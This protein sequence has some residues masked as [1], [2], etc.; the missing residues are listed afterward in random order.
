MSSLTADI[1]NFGTTFT[2]DL[3]VRL[4][5]NAE[6][7]SQN[8]DGLA[9][10]AG[11]EQKL[12]VTVGTTY[13]VAVA[14]N[15]AQAVS[16]DS[17][18]STQNFVSSILGDS[19]KAVTGALTSKSDG[20]YTVGSNNADVSITAG[21]A[22]T[23]MA[24]SGMTVVAMTGDCVVGAMAGELRIGA[25][26]G[27]SVGVTGSS[28]E[29]ISGNLSSV[30]KGNYTQ[31][32]FG[33]CNINSQQND[34]AISA[35]GNVGLFA[36]STFSVGAY[37]SGKVTA[38]DGDLNIGCTGG[39]L[40]LHA[41]G[42]RVKIDSFDAKIDIG[43]EAVNQDINIG[44]AG[45]RAINIGTTGSSVSVVADFSLGGNLTVAGNLNIIGRTNELN[46]EQLLIADKLIKLNDGADMTDELATGGGLQLNGATQHTLTWLKSEG[47]GASDIWSSNDSSFNVPTGQLYQIN[48]L[49][50]L[51]ETKMAVATNTDA[52][53]GLYMAGP[54]SISAPSA[55]QWRIRQDDS[56][57]A[58]VL[59]F[60][61]YIGTSW[62]TRFRMA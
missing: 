12:T 42:G 25:V 40:D 26:G 60:E 35:F 4:I 19:T 16:G 23:I 37:K 57:A 58:P 30:V 38:Q 5:G 1:S 11:A 17:Y 18:Y 44:T 8:A 49:L 50:A 33:L 31:S 21:G 22:S 55:G 39:V 45:T 52:D 32:S 48:K 62:V 27:M 43:T 3:Q 20:S 13:S 36:G 14:G 6:A 10:Y 61:K 28:T 29:A 51:S 7:G 34:V 15:F 24:Q 59:L 53:S 41:A 54:G 9:I 47:T 2:K 56:G 46:M